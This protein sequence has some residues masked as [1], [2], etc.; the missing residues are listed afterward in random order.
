MPD[1]TDPLNSMDQ[2]QYIVLI[3][4]RDN[5][6]VGDRGV[7]KSSTMIALESIW[8]HMGSVSEEIDTCVDSLASY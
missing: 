5:L 8:D 7:L 3:F 1:K 4:C 6:F 2:L